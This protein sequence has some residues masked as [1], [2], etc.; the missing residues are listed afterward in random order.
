MHINDI[1]LS[2]A[3]KGILQDWVFYLDR[4]HISSKSYKEKGCA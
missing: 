4:Q 2:H 3:N 1:F